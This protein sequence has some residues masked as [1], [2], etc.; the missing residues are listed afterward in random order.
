V[1]GC[2][3]RRARRSSGPRYR[4]PYLDRGRDGQGNAGRADSGAA[5]T[6]AEAPAD[7]TS[8]SVTNSIEVLIV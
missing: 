7:A 1:R 8:P 5:S 2:G 3:R 6:I 4:R